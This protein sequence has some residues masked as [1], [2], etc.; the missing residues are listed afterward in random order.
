MNYAGAYTIKN[1]E[2]EDAILWQM[3]RHELP[4]DHFWNVPLKYQ[5][6]YEEFIENEEYEHEKFLSIVKDYYENK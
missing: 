6:S 3:E 2:N 4:I 1:A 5:E